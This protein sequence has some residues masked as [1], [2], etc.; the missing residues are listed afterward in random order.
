MGARISPQVRHEQVLIHA[1]GALVAGFANAWMWG[2]YIRRVSGKGQPLASAGWD[3]MILSTGAVTQQ[4]WA[5]AGSSPLVL[6]GNLI[7]SAIGTYTVVRR[8]SRSGE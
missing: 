4:L 2:K 7:G 1:V 8:E 6:L 5:W 3:A